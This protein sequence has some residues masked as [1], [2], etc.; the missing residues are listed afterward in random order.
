MTSMPDFA[1][2]VLQAKAS[3]DHELAGIGQTFA[4]L[5]EAATYRSQATQAINVAKTYMVEA[6]NTLQRSKFSPTAI[7]TFRGRVSN[8]LTSTARQLAALGWY[9]GGGS[10][11][12]PS[13][14]IGEYLATQRDFLASYI[15]EITRVQGM[16]GGIY[17][18]TMYAQSL[19]QVYQRGYMRARGDKA[20]LPDLPAYPRDGSTACRT[21]CHC[22]WV[23]KHV[24]DTEYQAF[25]ELRPGEHCE[26]CLRRSHDWAPLRIVALSGVWQF[27]PGIEP[28]GGFGI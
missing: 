23:L 5:L 20:Q 22:R 6:A 15:D 3:L 18:A 24:S 16:P 9:A 27:A 19:E 11:K 2:I 28:F 10:G 26:D 17:R 1:A 7:D 8:A 21:N 4:A 14:I 13:E 12:E 25:W